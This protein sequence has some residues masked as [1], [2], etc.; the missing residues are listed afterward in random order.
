VNI[1]QLN[2]IE[3]AKQATGLTIIIDIMR[4][5][6]VE[7][8]A[9]GQGAKQI[10]PVATKEEAFLI[11]KEHPD[12]YLMG[13]EQH[14]F[15]IDGFDFGNSPSEIVK[16]D[17][18]SKTLIHRTSSG[19][20]GLVNA[21]NAHE[22]IFG[23]FVICS[24]II[25]YIKSKHYPDISIV[26]MD[27]EDIIFAKFLE[28]SLTGL[29][30]GKEKVREELWNDPGTD[31]FLDPLKPDFP[32]IDIDFALNFDKFNFVCLVKK[33]NNQMTTVPYFI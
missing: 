23:S 4:A 13:E 19:T 31:W 9:F 30:A 15:K 1:T 24:S 10:I 28:A 7:A 33:I 2:G 20:Q 29:P 25:R 16:K 3:G 32:P 17:L 5:A 12:F 8:Y 14:G 26:S 6:T 18:N 27:S 21:T 11:K 22:L